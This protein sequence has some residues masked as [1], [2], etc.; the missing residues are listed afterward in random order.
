[1]KIKE[2]S[3]FHYYTYDRYD[4]LKKNYLNRNFAEMLKIPLKLYSIKNI[5]SYF[6][7]LVYGT[8]ILEE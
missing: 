6:Q 7:V 1:M 3:N 4:I 5:E 8:L 2:S